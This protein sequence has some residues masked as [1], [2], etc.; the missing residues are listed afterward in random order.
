MLSLLWTIK[1]CFTRFKANFLLFIVK[2]LWQSEA[3]FL[4]FIVKDLWQSELAS[5]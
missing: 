2:D 4:L 3:N 5:H 1:I